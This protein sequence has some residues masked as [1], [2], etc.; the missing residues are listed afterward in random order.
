MTKSVALRDLFH[1]RWAMPALALLSRLRGAKFVT[2][3][4]ELGA[5]VGSMR[6]AVDSLIEAGWVMKNPGYGH[7]MRPEYILTD[8]GQA[9]GDCCR[10]LWESLD[11]IDA[12]AVALAKWSMPVV[13]ALS[14][15]ELRF[16]EIRSL[17]PGVTD[18]TLTK[19]LRALASAGLV[20]RSVEDTYPPTVS[21]CASGDARRLVP[22]LAELAKALTVE[23]D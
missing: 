7:P 4:R 18:R 22:H 5:S 17:C 11:T 14:E 1:R 19:A 21:Y 12:R 10:D 9:I 3:H 23:R 6:Q 2:L 15:R 8:R 16:G 13:F 20:E